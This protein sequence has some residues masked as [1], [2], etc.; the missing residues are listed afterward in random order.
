MNQSYFSYCLSLKRSRCSLAFRMFSKSK[1]ARLKFREYEKF[2]MFFHFLSFSLVGVCVCK[3][4]RVFQ[5]VQCS[6]SI[7]A[8]KTRGN[9]PCLFSSKLSGP[10]TAHLC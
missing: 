4:G 9:K 7:R 6:G 8:A 10:R 1:M 3:L 2:Q 5:R